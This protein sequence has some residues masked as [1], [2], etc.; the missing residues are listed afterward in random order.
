MGV[1]ALYMY[2][3][4]QGYEFSPRVFGLL[5]VMCGVNNAFK[6]YIESHNASRPSFPRIEPLP[7]PTTHTLMDTLEPSIDAGP[8]RTATAPAPDGLATP[9]QG[10]TVARRNSQRR[11]S[12]TGLKFLNELLE[13]HEHDHENNIVKR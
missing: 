2:S 1:E 9:V 4:I 11:Q 3:R 12:L 6:L 7:I 5:S 13:D 10:S 8:T